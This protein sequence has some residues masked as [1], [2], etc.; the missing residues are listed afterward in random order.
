[1]R[2]FA[3]ENTSGQAGVEST[4]ISIK[5]IDD[6]THTNIENQFRPTMQSL[7]GGK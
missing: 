6:Y 4:F 3:N 5:S 2:A 7:G 1:M